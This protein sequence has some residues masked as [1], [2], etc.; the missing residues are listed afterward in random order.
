MQQGYD[1]PQGQ[2]NYP[3]VGSSS[4]AGSRHS[5]HSGEEQQQQYPSAHP[6]PGHSDRGS[7]NRVQSAPAKERRIPERLEL[8]EEDYQDPGGGAGGGT[9]KRDKP[10][11]KER[12]KPT[13]SPDIRGGSLEFAQDG[14]GY[15]MDGVD[16]QGLGLGVEVEPH[17]HQFN[18]N[19]ISGLSNFSP[20]VGDS[21]GVKKSLRPKSS[22]GPGLRK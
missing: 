5:H 18:D 1:Q 14:D 13:S 19:D 9:R 7:V 11:R 6:S 3:P 12:G 20:S 8:E 21:D 4:Q 17:V 15:P 10:Q 2:Q 16:A 22:R